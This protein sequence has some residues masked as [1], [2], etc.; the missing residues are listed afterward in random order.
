MNETVV[1][2]P[3]I[4]RLAAACFTGQIWS[5]YGSLCLRASRDEVAG[6]LLPD[7]TLPST[8]R[9]YGGRWVP[10]T[11]QVT[12]TRM[13]SQGFLQNCQASERQCMYSAQDVKHALNK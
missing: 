13:P 9:A 3:G 7:V 11:S 12:F 8:P 5:D 2:I 10:V 6:C 1:V 4:S